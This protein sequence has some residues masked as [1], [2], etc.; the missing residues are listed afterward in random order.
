M[1]PP[2][3]QPAS[4]APSSHAPP[5]SPQQLFLRRAGFSAHGAQPPRQLASARSSSPPSTRQ[6]GPR[7]PPPHSSFASPCRIHRRKILHLKA[8]SPQQL[9]ASSCFQGGTPL[10]SRRPCKPPAQSRPP[11]PTSC[12]A[13]SPL[14]GPAPRARRPHVPRILPMRPGAAHA[15]AFSFPILALAALTASGIT[16]NQGSVSFSAASPLQCGRMIAGLNDTRPL[17]LSA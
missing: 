3:M 8:S 2:N 5:P 7:P 1:P 16:P 9:D 12:R 4:H 14:A 10:R 6:G 11:S 17:R 13:S 15:A